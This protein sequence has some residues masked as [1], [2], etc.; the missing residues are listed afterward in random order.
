MILHQPKTRLLIV[1]PDETTDTIT[2]RTFQ[3]DGQSMVTQIAM[4]DTHVAYSTSSEGMYVID[5]AK[6]ESQPELIAR[7]L[8]FRIDELSLEGA[9]LRAPNLSSCRRKGDY[10]AVDPVNRSMVH[11]THR[12]CPKKWATHVVGYGISSISEKHIFATV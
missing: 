1:N 7:Q 12:S 10:V 8:S 3:L 5:L 11:K 6:N 2:K 4:S 9:L